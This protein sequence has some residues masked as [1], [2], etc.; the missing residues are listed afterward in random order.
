MLKKWL[1]EWKVS[2]ELYKKLSFFALI[3]LSL[4]IVSGGAVRLTQSGLGCPTWPNCQGNQLVAQF[5]FHPMVEF[6]NRI[7][8]IFLTVAVMIATA[9]AFFRKPFRRDLAWLSM[10]MVGGLLAQVVLGGITVLEKLA[11]PFVMAHFLLSLVCVLDA[12]IL[13]YRASGSQDKPT[14]VV[15]KEVMWLGRIILGA[16]TFVVVIGTAVTGSGPHSGSPLAKRLPFPLRDVA[17]LHADGVLFL[18][19]L[20]LAMLFL[21]HQ[22]NAPENVLKR[23]RALLWLMAIQGAIGYTQYFSNLPALLVEFHIAG[24]AILWIAVLWFNLTLFDRG[25]MDKGPSDDEPSEITS[26]T[27]SSFGS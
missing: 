7:V 20:T 5:S 18:I 14:R 16:L 21:L 17:Q 15:T 8:T 13:Y 22:S 27:L 1:T 4:I 19:G 12:I 26:D 24:A 2:P 23:G 3:G 11:P 10:G 9:A 25:E 6:T